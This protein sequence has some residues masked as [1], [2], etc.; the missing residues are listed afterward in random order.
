MQRLGSPKVNECSSL[1]R[2][3]AARAVGPSSQRGASSSKKHRPSAAEPE[4]GQWEDG[5]SFFPLRHPG[6][7]PTIGAAL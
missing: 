1:H 4:P 2:C 7:F 6:D 5:E 3:L